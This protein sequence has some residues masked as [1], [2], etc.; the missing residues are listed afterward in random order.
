LPAA[1]TQ[2]KVLPDGGLI[3]SDAMQYQGQVP[4]VYGG[5][6]PSGWDCSGFVN[7]VLGHDLQMKLPGAT[8]AGFAGT[9]HGPVV[10]NYASW[11][12]AATIAS[13]EAGDL[14]IWVGV[15][16]GGHIGIA[17]SPTTMISAL[18]PALGTIVTPIIG[19]GPTGA[20]LIYRRIGQSGSLNVGC[21]PLLGFLALAA[22]RYSNH[23]ATPALSRS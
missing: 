3:A 17:Q 23:R 16:T 12:G 15:G 20:P 5:A 2:G 22:N 19:A 7:W 4:Y 11:T 9:S 14:C 18:N 6:N 10:V 21:V 8:K 1:N 13:P